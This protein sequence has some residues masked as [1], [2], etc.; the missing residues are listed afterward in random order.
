[1][2]RQYLYQ[3]LASLNEAGMLADLP[4]II[5]AGLSTNIQLREYQE[6]SFRYFVTYFE[7]DN[8]KKNKQ[9]HIL[10]HM[11]TGNGKTVIMA[12]LILYLYT[13]G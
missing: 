4:D 1:M 9:V 10:F 3:K 7:N 5:N 2:N 12:G 13:K 6:E 8:L 11:A